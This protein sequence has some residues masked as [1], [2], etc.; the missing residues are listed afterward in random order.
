MTSPQPT[1]PAPAQPVHLQAGPPQPGTRISGPTE[2]PRSHS[3]VERPTQDW[4]VS[5]VLTALRASPPF[6]LPKTLTDGDYHPHGTAEMTG[7][8]RGWGQGAVTRTAQLSSHRGRNPT[9][10]VRFQAGT[11]PRHLS[12][13][14]FCLHHARGIGSP[15]PLPVPPPGEPR[16]ALGPASL[17][18]VPLSTRALQTPARQQDDAGGKGRWEAVAKLRKNSACRAPRAFSSRTKL[19]DD[20]GM[21]LGPGPSEAG[22]PGRAAGE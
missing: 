16:A 14:P 1:R 13:P 7:A 10:A 21:K 6:I 19:G 18:S 4:G 12:V 9:G 11:V 3:R 22:G 17:S 8:Q 2:P 5:S 20:E 15:A